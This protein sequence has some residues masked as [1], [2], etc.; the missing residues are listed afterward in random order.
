MDKKQALFKLADLFTCKAFAK[1]LEDGTIIDLTEDLKEGMVESISELN[2][3]IYFNLINQNREE[4]DKIFS[5]VFNKQL[6]YF[7]AEGFGEITEECFVPI[8]QE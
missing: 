2:N 6:Y 3:G 1:S 4:F 8:C 7:V 5:R